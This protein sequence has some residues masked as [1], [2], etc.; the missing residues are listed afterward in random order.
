MQRYA[1]SASRKAVVYAGAND[2]MLHA[3]W[4]KGNST[5][6]AAID[7]YSL[8]YEAYAGDTDNAAYLTA[9]NTAAA[10][11]SLSSHTSIGQGTLGLY[12][13]HGIAESLQTGG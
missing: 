11:A 2:G 7:A 4:A 10:T 5:T 3:S 13:E 12:P 1:N 9:V 8:A 6:E